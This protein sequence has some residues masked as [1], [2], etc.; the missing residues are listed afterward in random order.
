MQNS[1]RNN[2]RGCS[3]RHHKFNN[4]SFRKLVAILVAVLLCAGLLPGITST[5]VLAAGTD[6]TGDLEFTYEAYNMTDN[7]PIEGTDYE[8]SWGVFRLKIYWEP[9]GSLNIKNEDYFELKMTFSDPIDMEILNDYKFPFD[10]ENAKGEKEK[11][12]EVTVAPDDNGD[13][14]AND[15]LIIAVFN[16][17][18]DDSLEASGYIEFYFQYAPQS[19][20]V[21]DYEWIINDETIAEGKVVVR[22][23]FDHTPFAYDSKLDKDGYVVGAYGGKE[24]LEKYENVVQWMGRVNGQSLTQDVFFNQYSSYTPPLPD[25][26]TISD[27]LGEQQILVPYYPYTDHD[28]PLKH[29]PANGVY[30]PNPPGEVAYFS[31]YTIDYAAVWNYFGNPGNKANL[32]EIWDKMDSDFDEIFPN[33]DSSHYTSIPASVAYLESGGIPVTMEMMLI[34]NWI[35]TAYIGWVTDLSAW[36]WR[37]YCPE[38]ADFVDN[39]ITLITGDDINDVSFTGPSTAYTGFSFNIDAS[40]IDGKVLY[41][42]CYSRVLNPALLEPVSHVINTLGLEAAGGIN[43]SYDKDDFIW[44]GGGGA[45]VGT[46]NTLTVFK[47]SD[48]IATDLSATFTLERLGKWD[49]VNNVHVP[50]LLVT[51][52]AT[53]GVMTM[54]TSAGGVAVSGL[55]GSYS[56]DDIYK[57]TEETPPADHE[58]YTEPIYFKIN[59]SGYAIT[60]CDS[61]GDPI[62]PATKPYGLCSSTG[63]DD[64]SGTCIYVVNTKIT[65]PDPVDLRI[66]VN[67]SVTGMSDA[68][69][70]GMFSFALIDMDE[71]E[72]VALAT[73]NVSGVVD[74]GNITYDDE[75]TYNYS[76]VEC[77]LV[78]E[79][80]ADA[81]QV[82]DPPATK[83]DSPKDGWTLDG[84]ALTLEVTVTEVAGELV[85]SADYSGGNT[86]T[87]TYTATATSTSL[88]IMASKD[89]TGKTKT[90]VAGK[91]LFALIDIDKNEVV[92]LAVNDSAG[93][94]SFGSITYDA[95]DTYNYSIVECGLVGETNAEA[96]SVGYPPE[97]KTVSPINGWTLDDTEY[98]MTVTVTKDSEVMKAVSSSTP[99]E[100]IFSNSY[101]LTPTNITFAGTKT[102][103]GA[104]LDGTDFTFSVKEAGTE[105]ATGANNGT[106][107]ITFTQITYTE[108]GAHSYVITESTPSAGWTANTSAISVYVKVVDNNDGTLT[109]TAYENPNFTDEITDADYLTFSNTFSTG[110]SP[111]GSLRVSKVLSGNAT[112]PAK[113]FTFTVSFSD[114]GTY[115]GVASGSSFTLKGGQSKTIT[116]IPVGVTYT[117]TEAEANTG[118]YTTTSTGASGT[119]SG[120]QSEA[121]FTNAYSTSSSGDTG[122]GWIETDTDADD[123]TDTDSDNDNDS[124]SDSDFDN[125][126]DYDY[127]NDN[128]YD[129][130][131]DTDTD[132]DNDNTGIYGQPVPTTEGNSL[133][134]DGDGWIEIGPN[135]VALGR[136]EYDPDLDDWVFFDWDVPLADALPETGHNSTIA[137]SLLLS[138]SLLIGLGVLIMPGRKP[139]HFMK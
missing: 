102:A 137:L 121:T 92:A 110:P 113:D 16:D 78:G 54:L 28:T 42:K 57:L 40:V 118:G 112:D 124:D 84:S 111:T 32:I 104:D 1:Q 132:T 109:A 134:E 26:I 21:D 119:I 14:Y 108:A 60:F 45:A 3:R 9:K 62:D 114:D 74:F 73:N 101:N 48:D 69:A 10:A 93:N 58:E 13:G 117:V 53:G 34:I 126:S 4:K 49:G 76:I 138:G 139:K 5:R 128:D 103:S 97:T 67:K 100:R 131:T 6:I 24:G 63:V 33:F 59:P 55:L 71:D 96:W 105:I 66:S 135:G 81:W 123:D 75:G 86:F 133:V 41:V 95:E 83:T 85:A 89:V 29:D 80:N 8:F 20:G 43:D 115:D 116:G 11:A 94:I 88:A 90:E 64:P 61:E 12:G 68:G 31:V 122:G 38:F 7:K 136:W 18:L 106:G 91:F 125:D 15:F 72:V 27:K 25:K 39:C 70:A 99:T 79:T 23:F 82:G 129:T 44:L 130:D 127:D 22:T 51:G 35:S 77:G 52:G 17:F 30:G 2:E 50:N 120:I 65:I 46:A 56:T 87:N 98:P 19:Y 107:T 37:A 36:D 47:R